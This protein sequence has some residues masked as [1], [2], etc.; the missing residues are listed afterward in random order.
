MIRCTCFDYKTATTH[1]YFMSG[2]HLGKFCQKNSSGSQTSV[3]H[4]TTFLSYFSTV[5]RF[6]AKISTTLVC[7][8]RQ[9]DGECFPEVDSGGNVF[10]TMEGILYF[11]VFQIQRYG[12]DMANP[13]H[14][15]ALKHVPKTII[16]TSNWTMR[17]WVIFMCFQ[18]APSKGNL[19]ISKET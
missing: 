15:T 18:F 4:V 12:F 19:I 11:S 16:F 8:S 14:R 5:L 1:T 13:N 10:E 9:Q 2:F 6:Y 7:S 17:A 3:T